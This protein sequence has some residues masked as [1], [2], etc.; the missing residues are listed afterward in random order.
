MFDT[1]KVSWVNPT[2][3]EKSALG[4][5]FIS[6]NFSAGFQPSNAFKNNFE[7]NFPHLFMICGSPH[8]S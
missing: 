1:N 5:W 7:Y 3:A 6:D 2:S 8:I 4:V